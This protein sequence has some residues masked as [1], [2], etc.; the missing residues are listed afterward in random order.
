MFDL[1]TEISR[2]Q[3]HPKADFNKKLIRAV[4]SNDVRTAGFILDMGINVAVTDKHGWAPLHHAAHTMSLDVIELFLKNGANVNMASAEF[5]DAQNCTPLMIVLFKASDDFYENEGGDNYT[6]FLKTIDIL[7]KSGAKDIPHSLGDRFLHICANHRLVRTAMFLLNKFPATDLIA[8]GFAGCTPLMCASRVV[9]YHMIKFLFRNRE[10]VNY[11]NF[12]SEDNCTALDYVDEYDGDNLSEKEMTRKILVS[13][14]ARCS[15]TKNEGLVQ[16]NGKV[17]TGAPYSRDS[18][19]SEVTQL[20]YEYQLALKYFQELKVKQTA[21]L[22]KL[23]LKVSDYKILTQF[24]NLDPRDPNLRTKQDLYGLTFSMLR[25]E[26]QLRILAGKYN[27][28]SSKLFGNKLPDNLHAKINDKIFR[29]QCVSTKGDGWCV[30]YAVGIEVSPTQAMREIITALKSTRI[31]LKLRLEIIDLISRSIYNNVYA[32]FPGNGNVRQ[33]NETFSIVGKDSAG[34]NINLEIQRLYN[35]CQSNDPNKRLK[36]EPKLFDYL[37][38][39]NVQE[40]Y[41]QSILNNRYADNLIVSAY[42]KLRGKQVYTF[43][44]FG[45]KRGRLFFDFDASTFV[46]AANCVYILYRPGATMGL[47][48]YNT[49]KLLNDLKLIGEKRPRDSDTPDNK[50]AR[51]GIPVDYSRNPKADDEGQNRNKRVKY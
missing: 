27:Q 11:I 6:R 23:K 21:L 39:Q 12:V 22:V 5:D 42:L 17:K 24:G 37:K 20:L 32:S 44:Y 8:P 36:A 50:K 49:L 35:A 40:A 25:Q 19:K 33:V 10:V 41:L 48:H 29:F 34:K 26:D 47:A 38:S 9:G 28:C 3:N 43:R 18:K 31:N 2:I 1:A 16:T 13:H 7:C 30:V 46:T 51:P 45:D 15:T 4:R 14:G